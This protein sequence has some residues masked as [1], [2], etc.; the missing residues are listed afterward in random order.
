M[1]LALQTLPEGYSWQKEGTKGQGH[2]PPSLF[3]RKTDTKIHA[4]PRYELHRQKTGWTAWKRDEIKKTTQKEKDRMQV[5]DGER[6]HRWIKP[7]SNRILQLLGLY[8]MSSQL[9]TQGLQPEN[10]HK[11]RILAIK[12][13]KVS[14]EGQS[15]SR[16]ILTAEP[17]LRPRR[18]SETRH[19]Q[20]KQKKGGGWWRRRNGG[21]RDEQTER[22]MWRQSHGWIKRGKEFQREIER[23]RGRGGRREGDIWIWLQAD[24]VMYVCQVISPWADSAECTGQNRASSVTAAERRFVWCAAEKHKVALSGEC[25]ALFLTVSGSAACRRPIGSL[26]HTY[27]YGGEKPAN[28]HQTFTPKTSLRYLFFPSGLDSNGLSDPRQMSGTSWCKHKNILMHLSFCLLG[29]CLTSIK[30]IP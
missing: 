15:K 30:A 18:R 26:V 27:R 25:V 1:P 6:K 2:P 5:K 23:E 21:T 19:R 20:K 24:D 13:Q 12:G 8:N 14:A 4:R 9:R 11:K 16:S 3:I 7:T 22:G 17:T 10:G 28:V 29:N